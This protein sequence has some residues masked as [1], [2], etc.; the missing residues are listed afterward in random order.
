MIVFLL[1]L[2]SM[3]SQFDRTV[4]NLMVE[5][6]KA[7]FALDDTHYGMLQSIRLRNLLRSGLCAHRAPGGPV[8]RRLIIAAGIGLFS[9]FA[10]ASGLARS[11]TQLFMTRIGVAVG[12]ASLTPAALSMFSDLFPSDRLSRPVSGFL[13]ECSGRPGTRL[14]RWRSCCSG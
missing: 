14:D 7:R 9:L 1:A 8:P 13:D 10:V 11:F 4:V 3:V 5:P 6:I 2:A 12:E